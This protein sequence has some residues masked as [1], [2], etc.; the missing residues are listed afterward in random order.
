MLTDE[1]RYKLLHLLEKDPQLSQRALA[2]R[3]GLSLGKVNF[4]VQALI[5]KGLIKAQNFRNHRNKSA[6]MY[7]LTPK[8]M[9]E[10]ARVTLRFFEKKLAEYEQLKAEIEALRRDAEQTRAAREDRRA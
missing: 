8:G 1:H 7:Y 3:L 5:E 6:Y 10:K 2:G 4:L 9:K